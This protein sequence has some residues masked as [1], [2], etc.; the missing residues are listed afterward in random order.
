M[1]RKSE[2]KKQEKP[3]EEEQQSVLALANDNDDLAEALSDVDFDT[4]GLEEVDNDD[5]KIPVKVFNMR[6]RDEN[7][8]PIPA[9][10]F[11]DSITEE[12]QKDIECVL[13]TLTKAN[14]WRRFDEEKQESEIVCKSLDR[15]TGTMQDGKQRPCEGCPD[16]QWRVDGTTGKRTRNCSPV[17]N[18]VG[19]ELPSQQPFIIRTKKTS[20]APSQRYLS[21]HFIG[22][23]V[24]K[25]QKKNVPLYAFKT[26][27]SLK[28][29]DDGGDY[30]IPA[31]KR[32]EMLTRQDI[33]A[34]SEQA[35]FYREVVQPILERAAA[36][37]AGSDSGAGKGPGTDFNPDDFADDD[38]GGGG[39]GDASATAAA[40]GGNRF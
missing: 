27:I 26:H 38:G 32:G 9:N 35:K 25:G 21:K 2:A 17:Y 12:I 40:E 7:N 16:K 4:D 24:V 34:M 30:S 36:H 28:M 8:E 18:F 14:E 31:F 19:V 5:I 1:A 20:L 37:D 10:R 22:R 13:L 39:G 23:R 3:A 11:W 33:L 29:A 15:V 6:G